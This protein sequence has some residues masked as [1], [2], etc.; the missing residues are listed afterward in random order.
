MIKPGEIQQIA[1][2]LGIR[3]TQ[4]EKDYVISWVLR[5][6]SHHNLLKESLIFKGGTALR[7][8]YINNFRLSEDLDFTYNERNF[9]ADELKCSFEEMIGWIAN[10]SRISLNIQNE[11]TTFNN[12]YLN[13]TGPLGG[14]GANKSIKIDISIDEILCNNPVEKPIKSLYSD[15]NEYFSILCYTL[16]E[17]FVEKLRSL[18][19]RTMPRD[20]YDVWYLLEIEKHEIENY[21]DDF[22]KK[23]L[24]KNLD[25]NK[26]V[27]TILQ[28]K[29][30]FKKLWELHLSNQIKVIPEFENIWRELRKHLRKIRHF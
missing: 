12:F 30:T 20:L 17:I 26:L 18:M 6:I 14:K 4:I 2:S 1:A 22:R 11:T 7:K 21:L 27:S 29:D 5:G 25:S 24:L 23:S 13:Y 9:I 16:N 19:Q 10:E 8:I 28:K 3:D 15:M